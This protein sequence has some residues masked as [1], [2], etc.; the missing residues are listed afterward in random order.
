MF[1]KTSFFFFLVISAASTGTIQA[2]EADYS[3]ELVSEEWTSLEIVKLV[4]GL[5][6]PAAMLF[7]G[8]WLDR[9]IKEF[10][11]R[12]WF[13]QKVIE[14][15]LDVYEKLTPKLNDI[16]CYFLQIGIWKEREPNEIIDMKRDI[17]KIAYIYAPL[18][19]P[20]FLER[21]NEFMGICYAMFRGDGKDAQLR[22]EV[23]PY[24][25]S[26]IND[27]DPDTVWKDE[28]DDCF[29]GAEE[30]STKKEV[31]Q[32]YKRIV[33]QIAIELGVEMENK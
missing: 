24:K 2:Q 5:L 19:S 7:V 31:G 15:R 9:R 23:G 16:M 14:K 4:V 6:M 33:D 28:W 1:N 17:D 13:N 32:G 25:Q 11:H 26:Y 10:E 29:T 30:A 12:Q 27:D 8:I 22:T 18:F 3:I 21:Y 20:L